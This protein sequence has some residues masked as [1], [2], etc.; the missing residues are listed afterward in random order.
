MEKD[1]R[2]RRMDADI[3]RFIAMEPEAELLQ[4]NAAGRTHDNSPS[5]RET[6]SSVWEWAEAAAST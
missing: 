5:N 4:L 1:L 6:E 2:R 3:L